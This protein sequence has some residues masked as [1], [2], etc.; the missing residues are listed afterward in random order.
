MTEICADWTYQGLPLIRLENDALRV[1]VLPTLGGKIWRLEHRGLRRQF[2]WH[3][4]RH[5]LRPLPVGANY[6]D[7]FFGGF[8]ELLPNDAPETVHGARLADHGE[9][10]TT[11]LAAQVA[12]ERLVLRGQ[13]PLTPL[14]YERSLR[15]EG[16]ALALDYTLASLSRGPLD[17][18]WKLH[19]A[20]RVS[21]GAEIE[22]PARLAR[23]ADPAWSRYARLAE[24]DWQKEPAAHR[25]PPLSGGTEFLYLL[26]LS[27]GECALCHRQEG[28]RFKMTFP[29]ELF[30]SVW[31]FASFGGWRDLEVLILEPCTCPQLS[32]AEC[33]KT[34]ACLRLEPAGVVTASVRVE[35]GAFS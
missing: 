22:V 12:G 5:R 18:L 31:V 25:V 34:G 11:P 8:D 17:L 19:P 13:L 7:H 3:H 35:V 6:D 10:W 23:V 1:E 2:L 26:D 15:L 28:W 33:A 14:A 16:S 24:F 9:L 27:A 30:S 4:P 21:E 29:K 32:L 20:L